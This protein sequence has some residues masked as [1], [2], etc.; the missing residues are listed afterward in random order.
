MVHSALTLSM[1]MSTS[2]IHNIRQYEKFSRIKS[3]FGQLICYSY[4]WP[5]G[6]TVSQ[7]PI[8]QEAGGKRL[9][10]GTNERRQRFQDNI[11]SSKIIFLRAGMNNFVL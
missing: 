7:R 10:P 11:I 2:D 1:Y 6:Q 9:S 4:D 5:V 8:R 3:K